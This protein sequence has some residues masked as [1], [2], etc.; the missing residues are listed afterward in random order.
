M[1]TNKMPKL[2][3]ASGALAGRFIVLKMTKSF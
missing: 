2:A 3:D 1:L